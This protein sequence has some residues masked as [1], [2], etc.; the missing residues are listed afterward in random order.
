ME[1]FSALPYVDPSQKIYHAPLRA[2]GNKMSREQRR[3]NAAVSESKKTRLWEDLTNHWRSQEVLAEELAKKHGKTVKWMKDAVLRV[4]K[5][6]AKR[7]AVSPHNVWKHAMSLKVN[8]DLA[9]G[10]KQGI[11]ALHDTAKE[12]G[13]WRDGP[14]N[15]MD[16]M[17]Q[18]VEAQQD[19]VKK[20]ICAK[21]LAQMATVTQVHKQIEE[22]LKALGWSCK[23]SSLCVTVKT[24][25][26]HLCTPVY[27]TDSISK[28]FIEIVLGWD[29]DEFCLKYE[30]FTLFRIKGVEMNN[31][32]K[33]V[34]VRR[35]VRGQVTCGLCERT[36]MNYEQDIVNEYRVVLEGWPSVTFNPALLGHGV[37]K[38]IL[39]VLLDTCKIEMLENGGSRR[40]SRKERSDK[41]K[42]R[43]SYGKGKK[44]A[45]RVDTSSDEDD[46]AQRSSSEE[47]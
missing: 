27:S 42:K 7:C 8:A 9:P 24:S 1:D 22:D 4:G 25:G 35:R 33:V 21:P 5:Y 12:Y 10:E 34:A 41:G 26:H 19:L 39:D 6:G 17:I 29:I 38:P 36:R 28:D 16:Q 46:T 13:S 37:L 40:E 43:G 3:T 47:L 15:Q 30:G 20:G 11:V 23:T 14:K 2:R 45:R 31:N 18:S 44:K 32:D